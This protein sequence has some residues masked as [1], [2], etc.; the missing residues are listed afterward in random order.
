VSVEAVT[1]QLRDTS[2]IAFPELAGSK[3]SG[4]CSKS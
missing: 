1:A 4:D 2:F 3:L